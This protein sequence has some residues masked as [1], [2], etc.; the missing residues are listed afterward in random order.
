[1]RSSTISLRIPENLAK[2]LEEIAKATERSKSFHVQK[3]IELYLQ[4]RADM[5]IS[6]DRLHDISDPIVSAIDMRKKLGI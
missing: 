1:M 5:Q 2:E 4:E 6:L 3:A